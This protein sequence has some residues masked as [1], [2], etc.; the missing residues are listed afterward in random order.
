MEDKTKEFI[1]HLDE[2]S[3]KKWLE[4]FEALKDVKDIYSIS[5]S[6]FPSEEL[7]AE[8]NLNKDIHFSIVNNNGDG[9]MKYFYKKMAVE[10]DCYYVRPDNYR[11]VTLLEVLQECIIQDTQNPDIKHIENSNNES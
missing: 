1:K 9:K 6:I 7:L 8:F 3:N 2:L 11:E 4:I 10:P 5:F